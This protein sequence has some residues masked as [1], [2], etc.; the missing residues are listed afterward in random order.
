MRATSVAVLVLLLAMPIVQA[1]G[2]PTPLESARALHDA[3]VRG[4]A[5]AAQA[6]YA[7]G[8]HGGIAAR[9]PAL[10]ANLTAALGSANAT[11]RAPAIGDMIAVGALERGDE[12][13]WRDVAAYQLN[14]SGPATDAPLFRAQATRALAIEVRQRMADALSLW[15]EPAKSAAQAE[16]AQVAFG[17]VAGAVEPVVGAPYA[18]QLA[19]EVASFVEAVQSGD[20]GEATDASGVASSILSEFIAPPTTMD[21][22][23][24]KV[25]SAAD[26]LGSEYDEYVKGGQVVDQDAYDH[27]VLGV[28]VP[29][30]EQRWSAVEGDVAKGWPAQEAALDQ[31]VDSLKEKVAAKAPNAEVAALVQ[32]IHREAA[33]VT[34]SAG[35]PSGSSSYEADAAALHDAVA[36][37]LALAQAGDKAGALS[38]LQAAY[39]D[40]YGPRLEPRVL[41]TSPAMNRDIES[42]LNQQLPDAVKRGASADE[43]RALSDALD[44]KVQ[45][46][47]A[48]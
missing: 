25:V 4:D 37:G 2:D 31:A 16:A 45:D 28:F 5:V 9:D 43:L 1:T 42:I 29:G 8:L 40:V 18:A 41:A 30:L 24:A 19:D 6:A 7:Q 46:A 47:G 26:L 35:A 27:E 21:E 32:T 38:A 20:K 48:L 11:V 14:L 17:P 23:L 13:P 33:E 10:D 44:A 39:L 34:P 3:L 15:D 22:R 12:Q 36:R